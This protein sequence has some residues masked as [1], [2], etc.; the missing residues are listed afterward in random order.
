MSRARAERLW[1]TA[2]LALTLAVLVGTMVAERCTEDTFPRLL[3]RARGGATHGERCRA[4][5]Q[6]A[7]RGYWDERPTAALL[8]FLAEAPPDLAAF[9]RD[10]Y[11]HLLGQRTGVNGRGGC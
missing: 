7:E 11:G 3:E 6:L 5:H 10:A 2:A 9:V 4:M 8:E 1:I